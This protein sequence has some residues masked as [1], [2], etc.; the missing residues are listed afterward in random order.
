M[1][2]RMTCTVAIVG[3][4]PV[5]LTLA[6]DLASRGIDTVIVTGVDAPMGTAV[7]VSGR[8]AGPIGTPIDGKAVAIVRLDRF[9]G[10]E[11]TVADKPVTVTLPSWATD[12]LGES[13][14]AE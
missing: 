12:R 4:G 5:G 1:T 8:D 9:D 10:G 11:V 7:R 3:A 6:L 13:A 14:V 2:S